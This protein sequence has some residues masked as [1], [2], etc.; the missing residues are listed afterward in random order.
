MTSSVFEPLDTHTFLRNRETSRTGT[1]EQFGCSWEQEIPL[2]SS[3]DFLSAPCEFECE[4]K[5]VPKGGRLQEKT[6]KK[7]ERSADKS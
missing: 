7:E 5:I 4:K 1:A 2:A 6:Q 3:D